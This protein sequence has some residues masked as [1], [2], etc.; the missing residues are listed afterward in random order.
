MM[1]DVV[2]SIAMLV[3]GLLAIVILLRILV[4]VHRQNWRVKELETRMKAMETMEVD[5]TTLAEAKKG[6]Q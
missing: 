4:I 6:Q 2:Q 1:L 5:P 3:I